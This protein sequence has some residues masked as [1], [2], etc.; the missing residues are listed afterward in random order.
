M[1][2]IIMLSV[3]AIFSQSNLGAEKTC[4]HN[5]LTKVDGRRLFKVKKSQWLFAVSTLTSKVLLIR[6]CCMLH[7]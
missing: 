1:D 6:C 4:C 7:H 2:V 5:H 3:L